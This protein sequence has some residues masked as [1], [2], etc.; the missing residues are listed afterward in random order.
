MHEQ[1]L[2]VQML[3]GDDYLYVVL[4][5]L[6]HHVVG[7]VAAIDAVAAI[8]AI[9]ATAAVGTMKGGL[10]R[11]KQ[12]Q[13]HVVE[14]MTVLQQPAN[15]QRGGVN[16]VVG[17]ALF[18]E[19]PGLNLKRWNVLQTTSVAVGGR[20]KGQHRTRRVRRV[21]VGIKQKGVGCKPNILQH[22]LRRVVVPGTGQ[23]GFWWQPWG[24][25][26]SSARVVPCGVACFVP[27]IPSTAVFHV[28][29]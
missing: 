27:A 8:A 16:G 22:T 11:G 28:E 12:R 26:S 3:V 9:A 5:Q 10:Q 23:G 18:R 4:F 20:H 19:R 17:P 29:K 6:L 2:F 15:H 7:A 25:N 1:F 21:V 14:K 24:S 13:D